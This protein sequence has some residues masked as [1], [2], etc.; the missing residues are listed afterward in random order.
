[1]HGTG[2][3]LGGFLTH[4][5]G[6]TIITV[7]SLGLDPELLLN[8]VKTSKAKT[9]VI[10][11]DAFAKPILA[12][13]DKAKEHNKPYDISSL[14]TLISSG[15]IWSAKVKE[16]LLKHHDMNLFDSMGSSE[17]GMGSSMSSRNKPAQTAKFKMNSNVIVLS[18]ENKLVEP[19]SGIRGKIGTSGLVPI[20]YYKDPEK[21]ASTFKD[22]DG[23]RY[24]FPGDYAMVES[25][26]SITLLGRG[27]NC[28]N[29]A[30]EKIYPEEVEEAIKLDSNIY[31]CL[32]VGIDDERFGQK[33]VA[34]ASFEK[35]KEILFDELIKNTR[36]HLSGYKLPKM[37]KFVDEVKRAPNGKA[38]YK[39]ALEIAKS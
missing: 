21:S 36:N 4:V 14:Q 38:D 27:S 19:G 28:I 7:P 15:V 33:V 16:G 24:S 11:G 23:I 30:G 1:M 8:Q 35:N 22:F 9:M 25:D 37:I 34:V 39:W 17:G 26:G 2:M 10:V 32:V 5:L 31:D 6:G 3:F 20:G 12:E 18:D 13:L 29:S